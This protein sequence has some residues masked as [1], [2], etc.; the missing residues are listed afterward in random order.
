MSTLEDHF[1]GICQDLDA[2]QHSQ[3]SG[4]LG[5]MADQQQAHNDATKIAKE[6][7]ATMTVSGFI[8]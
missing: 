4:A 8:M 6:E 7:K 5:R 2:Q 1:P 3:I